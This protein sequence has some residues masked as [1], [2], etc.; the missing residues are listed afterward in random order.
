MIE[1]KKKRHSDDIDPVDAPDQFVQTAGASVGWAAQNRSKFMLGVLAA[2]AI[3]GIVAGYFY[4][5]DSQETAMSNALTSAVQVMRAPIGDARNPDAIASP[6][7]SK[8]SEDT[9]EIRFDS[10]SV[11]YAE[12]A[13]KADQVLTEFPDEPVGEFAKLIKARALHGQG[14]YAEAAALYKQ[15][16]DAHAGAQEQVFVLQSLA[17][18]QAA[19]GES[20]AAV[21]SLEALK[22]VNE[23]AWG[24]MAGYQIA[25]IHEAAG[26]KDKARKEYESL[27]EKYPDSS[28]AELV[29]MHL[30]FL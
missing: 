23:E 16:S 25:R 15:W 13:T 30:D 12:L 4:Y 14:K 17:T 27:L 5:V 20:D 26:Q 21:G 1:I 8:P 6:P 11:K 22:A 24:E 9:N 7:S 28:R 2:I 10:S 3:G 18:S 19:A 29:K